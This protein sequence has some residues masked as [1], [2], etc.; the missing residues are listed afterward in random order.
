MWVYL[1]CIQKY[2]IFFRT[3]FISSEKILY[4][5]YLL[6]C[7]IISLDS[8]ISGTFQVVVNDMD[9]G[10]DFKKPDVSLLEFLQSKF[11]ISEFNW[12]DN[13]DF[14]NTWM[15]TTFRLAYWLACLLLI[16]CPVSVSQNVL[17]PPVEPSLPNAGPGS[18]LLLLGD[19]GTVYVPAQVSRAAIQRLAGWQRPA[20]R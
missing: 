6:Y 2:N 20:R 13:I 17:A 15:K 18:V 12:L 14:S 4:L 5:L 1:H 3:N 10:A 16:W 7:Y 11:S 19:R 9:T 8:F